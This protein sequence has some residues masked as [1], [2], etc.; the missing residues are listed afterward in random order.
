[1]G[2]GE[3]SGHELVFMM[4]LLKQLNGPTALLEFL[5]STITRDLRFLA[6]YKGKLTVSPVSVCVCVC[7]RVHV[8]VRVCCVCSSL[9]YVVCTN[10]LSIN[11]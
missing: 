6:P 5:N 3:D 9:L 1:M 10:C 2:G 4:H 8:R 11:Y 7:V